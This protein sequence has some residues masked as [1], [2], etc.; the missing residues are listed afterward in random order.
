MAKCMASATCRLTSV[1]THRHSRELVVR[2]AAISVASAET[3]AKGQNAANATSVA[4]DA[5]T[6]IVVEVAEKAVAAVTEAAVA[7]VDN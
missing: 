1:P 2:H 5:T 7:G 3:V 4:V 6:E